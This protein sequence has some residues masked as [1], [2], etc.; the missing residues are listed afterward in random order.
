MRAMRSD[1]VLALKDW[2]RKIPGLARIKRFFFPP[3]RPLSGIERIARYRQELPPASELKVVFGGHW[4]TNP[5]WLLL[6][7]QDQDVT[8]V[9]QFPDSTVDIVFCEHVIEHVPFK[10]GVFFL[11]ESFRI[12]K[13]GGVCRILCPM[14]DRLMAADFSDA[15]GREYLR[16]SVLPHFGPEQE[17]LVDTL[18]LKGIGEDPLPFLFNAIYMGHQHRFIWSSSL[19]IRVMNAI[20]FR[21]VQRRSPGE[22]VRADACIERRQRGIYLGNDWRENAKSNRVYDAESFVV[23]GVK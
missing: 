1:T 7:E 4:S 19:M 20:G 14:L 6:T 11:Q 3:P 2:A 17:L 15:D 8:K 12:L 5:G 22:G 13:P 23:E 10:S 16:N 9:L 18:G 21:D